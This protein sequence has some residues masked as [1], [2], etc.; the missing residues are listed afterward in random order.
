MICH[1]RVIVCAQSFPLVT[2]FTAK[3]AT[4]VPQQGARTVGG[5]K[6][7]ALLQVITLSAEQLTL[8]EHCVTTRNAGVLVII[9]QR[10]ETTTV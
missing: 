6:F 10:L 5:S 4:F 8:R 1:V 3:I 9:P 7:H 2:V